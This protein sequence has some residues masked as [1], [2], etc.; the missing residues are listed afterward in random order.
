MITRIFKIFAL[1]F[2][3]IAVSSTN[4]QSIWKQ[5]YKDSFNRVEISGNPKLA[6]GVSGTSL[7]LTAVD[8]KERLLLIRFFGKK[9]NWDGLIISKKHPIYGDVHCYEEEKQT[10]CVGVDGSTT[11][12]VLTTNQTY[13]E[14][15]QDYTRAQLNLRD[16]LAARQVREGNS[17]SISNAKLNL[18]KNRHPFEYGGSFQTIEN[19]QDF[20]T[21]LVVYGKVNYPSPPRLLDRNEWNGNE[22]P[23][24]FE[25]IGY[26]KSKIKTKDDETVGVIHTSINWAGDERKRYVRYAWS[27]PIDWSKVEKIHSSTHINNDFSFSGKYLDDYAWPIEGKYGWDVKS[28][29]RNAGPKDGKI[30]SYENYDVTL[31]GSNSEIIARMRYVINFLRANCSML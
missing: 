4:A 1:G 26:C 17:V 27:Q 12:V 2:V 21:H 30:Y 15:L 18:T 14:F 25:T 13:H 29:L 31:G 9:I 10:Y 24:V 7:V 19:A 28:I 3:T 11:P 22:E 16:Q 6:Y 5:V 23:M 20:L 8:E